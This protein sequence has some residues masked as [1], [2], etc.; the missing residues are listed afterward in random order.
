MKKIYYF[1]FILLIA[2]FLVAAQEIATEE[3]NYINYFLKEQGID[4]IKTVEKVN[5]TTL[6]EEIDISNVNENQIG[7]Y[8]VTYEENGIEKKLFVFSYSDEEFKKPDIKTISEKN[9]LTFSKPDSVNSGYINSGYI[10]LNSGSII[11]LSTTAN[12][13]NGK[14]IVEV[15]KNGQPMLIS[16]EFFNN[17]DFDLESKNLDTFEIGDVISIYIKTEGGASVENLNSL[18]LIESE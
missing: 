18:I 10:M 6:P 8:G 16:N 14:I 12:V 2:I 9:Y 15:H 7:V 5:E 17:Y 4:T 13:D 1:I 3:E 11:G